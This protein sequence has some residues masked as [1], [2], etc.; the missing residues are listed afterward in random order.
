[1]DLDVVVGGPDPINFVYAQKRDAAAGF[2]GGLDRQSFKIFSFGLKSRHHFMQLRA[3]RFEVFAANPISGPFERFK[4]TLPVNRLQQIIERAHLES[5]Q[6]VFIISG[7]ENDMRHLFYAD[8][9]DYSEP[10]QPWHLNIEKDQIG[11][12][13]QDDLHSLPSIPAFADDFDIRL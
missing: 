8:G 2:T 7:D 12:V 5:S 11:D 9:L 4:K 1:M 10:V 6:R 3:N 13:T